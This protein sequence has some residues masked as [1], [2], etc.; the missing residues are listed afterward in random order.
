MGTVFAILSKR[1]AL[2]SGV[3]IITALWI[4]AGIVRKWMV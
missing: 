1:D 4:L 3:S 2:G